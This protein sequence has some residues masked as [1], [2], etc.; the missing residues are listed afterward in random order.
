MLQEADLSI[1]EERTLGSSRTFGGWIFHLFEAALLLELRENLLPICGNQPDEIAPPLDLPIGASYHEHFP[2]GRGHSRGDLPDD[3]VEP[4]HISVALDE[5]GHAT[6]RPRPRPTREEAR[7]HPEQVRRGGL[8]ENAANRAASD[9]QAIGESD[10]QV[11][12]PLSE[13]PQRYDGGVI[14]HDFVAA[15]KNGHARRLHRLASTACCSQSFI[16]FGQTAK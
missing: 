11:K 8:F 15:A 4:C 7:V 5:L 3:C 16:G 2:L 6:G 1:S 9:T 13:L 14:I 12:F 10:S